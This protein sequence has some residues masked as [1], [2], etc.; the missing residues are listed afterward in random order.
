MNIYRVSQTENNHYDTYDSIIV[1]AETEDDARNT[2][3][4][5]YEKWGEEYSS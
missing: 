3:P 5:E 2:L 4:S 1:A